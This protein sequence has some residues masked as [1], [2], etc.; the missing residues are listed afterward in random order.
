M[1]GCKPLSDSEISKSLSSLYTIRNKCLF[2]L[3]LR[4]GFR[5]SELLSIKVSQVLQ[6]GTISSHI[7]VNRSNMKGSN[8]SRSVKLHNDAI[9]A[10]KLH[11]EAND[12]THDDYLFKSR[13]GGPISR[14][15]AWRIL[16][17]AYKRAEI[18]GR[19]G[20]H[21][22]RK[23]FAVRVHNAANK[24]LIKTQKAM[25]HKSMN[26]TV[27]YLDVDQPEIDDLITKLK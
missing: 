8:A 27:S 12:L 5:I 26:S 3:G 17:K 7:T 10:I 24:D 9:E 11:I 16:N 4:T 15:Q 6:Y 23:S 1:P 13:L 18:T 2:I 22:M 14:V 25:G 19:T 21:S 20:T